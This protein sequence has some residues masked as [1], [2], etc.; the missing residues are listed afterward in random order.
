MHFSAS[1]RWKGVDLDAAIEKQRSWWVVWIHTPEYL[2][3]KD[4]TLHIR[5]HRSWWP[6]TQ[7]CEV[8]SLW[9]QA[10]Q[11]D[12]AGWSL[13]FQTNQKWGYSK[14]LS[15]QGNSLEVKARHSYLL[16]HIFV[17]VTWRQQPLIHSCEFIWHSC[18]PGQRDCWS[19]RGCSGAAQ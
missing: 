11:N 17:S 14:I 10:T 18:T 15:F 8:T 5:L 3:T 1:S 7:S 2:Y 16:S 9:K 12:G 6:Q 13:F 19:K 4:R